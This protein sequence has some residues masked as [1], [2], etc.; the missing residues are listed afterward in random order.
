MMSSQRRI[1]EN[2]SGYG[3]YVTSG[4]ETKCRQDCS[5]VIYA[6]AKAQRRRVS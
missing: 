4:G 1:G 5:A 2:S 6:C 3:A